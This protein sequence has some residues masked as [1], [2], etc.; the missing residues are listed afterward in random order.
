MENASLIL[1]GAGALAYLALAWVLILGWRAELYAAS[2][3]VAVTD[4]FLVICQR[5]VDLR[6][7]KVLCQQLLQP[8][9]IALMV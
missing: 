7:R 4:R 2:L 6:A 1:F 9:A 5:I 8:L 3:F